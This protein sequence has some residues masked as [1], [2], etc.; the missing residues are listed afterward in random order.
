MTELEGQMIDPA[1]IIETD[2]TTYAFK[3]PWIF[4]SQLM[5]VRIV[6]YKRDSYPYPERAYVTHIEVDPSCVDS[7]LKNHGRYKIH[8]NYD[9]TFDEAIED[10]I[11]RY[12][13]E[14]VL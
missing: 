9:L 11:Q 5:E 12:K 10:A 3:S 7:D 6:A 14:Q 4:T 13:K 1:S 8:G 2:E